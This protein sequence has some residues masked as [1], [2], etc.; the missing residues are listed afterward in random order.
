M[1][2]SMYTFE[3]LKEIRGVLRGSL[4]KLCPLRLSAMLSQQALDLELEQLLGS[5]ALHTHHG[6][7]NAPNHQHSSEQLR[8]KDRLDD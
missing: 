6:R 7:N 8:S 3:T 5:A 1:W 4:A 2:G